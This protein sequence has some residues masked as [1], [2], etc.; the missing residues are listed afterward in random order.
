MNQQTQK[1]IVLCSISGMVCGILLTYYG[2]CPGH[3]NASSA[4]Y[5]CQLMALRTP[6]KLNLHW[7][8]WLPGLLFGLVFA[9][10]NLTQK[11][12]VVVFTLVSGVIYYLA[13]LIFAL[14]MSATDYHWTSVA[15]AL[16]LILGSII[17]GFFGAFTLVL[18][19]KYLAR[20]PF[21]FWKD[22]V[23]AAIGAFAGILFFGSFMLGIFIY[24]I[25]LWSLGFLIWQV[26]VG[27]SL[28]SALQKPSPA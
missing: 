3:L 16:L 11:S 22:I 10:A 9:I 8:N 14:F 21:V 13:G 25:A 5:E 1:T 2:S 4:L 12:G 15:I 27:L 24:P 19:G 26:W 20:I 18:I 28:T 23:T 17:S 7:I 6:L